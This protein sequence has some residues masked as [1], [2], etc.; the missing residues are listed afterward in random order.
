VSR[1]AD[2]AAVFVDVDGTLVDSNYHHA[3]AWSRAL[4]D[5]GENARLAAIHR[6]VGMG[7][8]ELLRSLV[9]RDDQAIAASWREHFD[10]LLPEIVAFDGAAELLRALRACG[11]VVVLATSSPTDLLDVLRAKIGADDAIDVVVTANDVDRAKPEPDI[12]DAALAKVDVGHDRAM[13]IGD[14]VW[15]VEAATRAGLPCTAFETG[16]F[17]RL[18]LEAGGAIAVYRDPRALVEQLRTSPLAS[19]ASTR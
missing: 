19:L 8:S 4:R 15:D 17:S 10:A 9:G 5:H 1:G 2:R 13:V 18:E 3:I 6:A 12:F 7:S 14:S 11:L 16:G